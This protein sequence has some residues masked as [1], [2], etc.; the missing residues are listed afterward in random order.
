MNERRN[1]ERIDIRLPVVLLRNDK[2]GKRMFELRAPAVTRNLSLK[3]VFCEATYALKQGTRLTLT[4]ALEG[5][6][7][8][9]A[10]AEVVHSIPVGDAKHE[11]GMGFQFISIDKT[12]RERLLRFFVSDRIRDFYEGRFAVQFEHLTKQIT[13][14]DAAL[15]INLWEESR[16]QG[17]E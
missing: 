11:A 13:L 15:L 17:T 9:R 16:S 3:G 14:R 1:S 6:D 7:E 2:S 5:G 4:L 12:N 8:F 10:A